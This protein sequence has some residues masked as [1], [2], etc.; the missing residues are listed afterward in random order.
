LALLK[1]HYCHQKI[2][3]KNGVMFSPLLNG[4]LLYQ[5][6]SFFV[7]IMN[8]NCIAIMLPSFDQNPASWLG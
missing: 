8:S 7:V 5:H 1:A 4:A 6:A 3:G 2:V